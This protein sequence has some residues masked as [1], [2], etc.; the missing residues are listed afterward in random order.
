MTTIKIDGQDYDVE[1]L[2]PAA[3]QQLD[4]LQFAESEINRMQAHV[5]VLKTAQLAYGRAL[6]EAV[7]KAAAEATQASQDVSLN[8][9]GETIKFG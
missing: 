4:M 2:P 1:T 8:V 5:A 3:R 9:S 7:Q 6:R